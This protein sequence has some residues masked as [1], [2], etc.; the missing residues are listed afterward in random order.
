MV[1][2]VCLA[3]VPIY[4]YAVGG[5]YTTSSDTPL[6][7]SAKLLAHQYPDA[8]SAYAADWNQHIDKCKNGSP[9]LIFI[10][11]L[12][13]GYPVPGDV[14]K[15]KVIGTTDRESCALGNEGEYLTAAERY[16]VCNGNQVEAHYW[17]NVNDCPVPRIDREKSRGKP[18][19]PC[20]GVSDPVHPG[21]GSKYDRLVIYRGAGQFPLDLTIAYDGGT[22]SSPVI[23]IANQSLGSQRVHSYMRGIRL[24]TLG[25]SATAYVLR[26]DGKTYAFDRNGDA[27]LGDADV[28]DKLVASYAADGGVERW[29]YYTKEMDVEIYDN[30]GRLI[31]VSRAGFTQHL[32]YGVTGRLDAVSDPEGR[33]IR[34]NYRDDGLLDY[35]S[36]PNGQV[37]FVYNENRMLSRVT[38]Q[39]STHIDYLY[40]ADQHNGAS[41]H[42]LTG[43]VNEAGHLVDSTSYDNA[44]RVILDKGPDIS[45]STSIVYG[46]APD[47]SQRVTVTN[48]SG[49]IQ[50]MDLVAI[51]GVLLPTRMTHSCEGCTT[52][53][54]SYVYDAKGNIT[55]QTESNGSVTS[56]TYDDNGLVVKSIRAAGTSD[57]VVTNTTWNAML[58]K[59][60]TRTVADALGKISEKR[61][62]S[63]NAAGQVTAE[64]VID[65]IK[66]PSYVCEPSGVVTDGVR[67]TVMTYC[68]AVDG[69]S[70]PLSG[71]LVSTDGPRAD[72]SDTIH[73]TYYMT[74]DESG[75]ASSGGTCH[76]A[77]DVHTITDGAG[78]VTTYVTYDKAGRP[79][80]IKAPN[81]VLTDLTYTSRGWLATKAVRASADGLPSSGDAVD[82]FLYNPDGTIRQVRDLDNVVTTYTYDVA[83]RLT[84]ITDGS[85]NRYHY[86]LDVAGRRTREDVLAADG[87]VVRTTSRTFNPLGQLTTI[88]DGLGRTVFN[89]LGAGSYDANGN[90]VLSQDGLGIKQK[91]IFDGLNRLVSTLRN[92]QG[93]D[94]AT[95]DTQSV[96]SFDSMDRVVGFSDPDGLNTTYDIDAFGNPV[97]LHSPDTGITKNSFDLGG[98]VLNSVDATNVSHSSTYDANNRITS[99]SYAD[100]SQNINYKYDEDDA[101]TGCTG[102]FGKGHLTRIVESNGGL[103][104]C[105]DARG[106]VVRKQQRVGPTIATISYAWTAGN[107]LASIT[108]A[109][110]TLVVYTRDVNGRIS[111]VAV[112]PSAGAAAITVVSHVTYLPFGPVLSYVLGSGQTLTRS[113]DANGRLLDIVSG[114]FSW[115]VSRDVMGNVAALGNA[116]GVNVATEIYNYDALYR[117]AGVSDGMGDVIEAYTYNKT[118]DRLSKVAPGMLTGAYTYR[119]GTHQLLNI[120]AM[121]RQVDARGNTT[122][123][124]LASGT[125]EFGYSPRN[126]LT[127]VKIGGENAGAYVINALGQRIQK[128]ADGVTTRFD[129]D[130]MAGLLSESSGGIDRDY[131]WMDGLPVGIIDKKGEAITVGYIHADGLNSPRVVTNMAGDVLWEWRYAANPFGE[132]PPVSGVGYKLNL[133]FPGQYF[134]AESGL[135]YNV[136]RDYEVATGRY[137]QSDPIGLDGGPS[138]YAYASSNPYN[139]YD[140]SGTLDMSGPL[141]QALRRAAIVDAAG[142]GP[143]DPIG[144]VA[145]IGAFAATLADEIARGANQAEVHRICDEPPPPNLNECELAKW[146][147]QK[148]LQCRAVRQRMADK[149]FGGT[150]DDGHAE[151]MDQLDAEIK[152]QREAVDRKCRPCP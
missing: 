127:S 118:G 46:T 124:M 54:T 146:K 59:P 2:G 143:E 20:E 63:Y 111:S 71:L 136:H 41:F 65:T 11:V 62:W 121:N 86:T 8:Y 139:R 126:R 119:S 51:A 77:G 117:L 14:F 78:L 60:L 140:P 56:F 80:R 21:T 53:A 24:S 109:S 75:C 131:V 35:V 7:A 18:K 50:E 55:T 16:S 15:A 125:Y 49:D 3:R 92:Y 91:Q 4:F 19:C 32:S 99:T 149:W 45:G 138:T 106:N 43:V 142:G 23:N 58:R 104:Y 25:S 74:P 123:S 102:G 36:L 39:D 72:V 134:D 83:A 148:A 137:I 98:N 96:V 132:R 90:L 122:S 6:Q 69:A 66:A 151:R 76:R 87:S 128:I 57:A 73:Y 42:D 29:T 81:G 10:G 48:P 27:W 93:A 145:A 52:Q 85:G 101:V 129:Y 112:T 30:A 110:G 150:Y 33:S 22:G 26:D 108:T 13:A 79:A 5:W 38:W 141:G 40:E 9:A 97:S 144:D 120:G 114:A 88:T 84:D 37:S 133:R 47:G 105:Y 44:E 67:R 113:Y 82:T 28:L 94:A 116:S 68:A 130:E 147:L 31:S 95:R 100:V 34:F 17:R 70:C 152:R 115:H 89:A 1:S 107:R 61:G 103:V 135:N 64:C 12:D